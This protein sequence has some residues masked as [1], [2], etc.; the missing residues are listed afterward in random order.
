[1]RGRTVIAGVLASVCAFVAADPQNWFPIQV[2][3]M[4]HDD[5]SSSRSHPHSKLV[6]RSV[7]QQRRDYAQSLAT[8]T[9][10]DTIGDPLDIQHLSPRGSRKNVT[11]DDLDK[12]YSDSFHGIITWYTGVDLL[13][14]EQ[15]SIQPVGFHN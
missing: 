11:Q 7:L 10:R 4:M 12:E 15:K 8:F 6:R 2:G 14:R 13:D 3:L 9:R 1:M 5:A